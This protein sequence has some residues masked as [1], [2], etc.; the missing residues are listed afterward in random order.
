MEGL[1]QVSDPHTPSI[2]H[3]IIYKYI[4]I[5]ICMLYTTYIYINDIYI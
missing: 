3:H 1:F 2:I 5:Y 4:Y